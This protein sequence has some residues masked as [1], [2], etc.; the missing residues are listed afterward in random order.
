[1]NN[2]TYLATAIQ[3]AQASSKLHQFYAG[4]DLGISTKS[5]DIDLVTKV[6]KLCEEKIREIISSAHP[7]H[8]ILGE[9]GGESVGN[10]SHRW[11]VDPLDGTVN[12]AHGFPFYCVSIGLEIDGVMEVGVVLDSVR[13]EMFTATRG[14]GAFCNG[15]KIS[16]SSEPALK[17]CLVATGFPYDEAGL[18]RS[19]EVFAKVHQKVRAI[20]RPGSAALDLSYVACGRID[21]FWE[22]KLNAW[23]VAAGMLLIQEAGGTITGIHGE[24]YSVHDNKIVA[25]NG[26]IHA[27]LL[28]ALELDS[29]TA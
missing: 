22:L 26:H 15:V 20:R 14:G 4:S 1:M 16:V 18:K 7:E 2:S 28:A 17:K 29:A 8:V 27:K 6:D 13:G 23:D 21:G 11:I 9:E 19:L 24:P 5:S 10:A 25:T 3:A 12:Y